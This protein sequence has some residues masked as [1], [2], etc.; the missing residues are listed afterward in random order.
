M[1]V[2]SVVVEEDVDGIVLQWSQGYLSNLNFDQ[3]H[4]RKFTKN[5]GYLS[6]LPLLL[7]MSLPH[8]TCGLNCY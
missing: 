5:K 8:K 1:A 4:L 3:R 6:N 2:H 7:I